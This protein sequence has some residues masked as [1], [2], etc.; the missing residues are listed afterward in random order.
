M[1]GG[2]DDGCSAFLFFCHAYILT[3]TCCIS[4]IFGQ[5]PAPLSPMF[6]SVKTHI[7]QYSTGDFSQVLHQYTQWLSYPLK[8]IQWKCSCCSFAVVFV[9][10]VMLFT[11][12]RCSGG[13]G[14]HSNCKPF[15]CIPNS[16]LSE[17]TCVVYAYR[18][19]Q[20]IYL[21]IWNYTF[22]TVAHDVC[23]YRCIHQNIQTI[24]K[25]NSYNSWYL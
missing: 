20:F 22:E 24:S 4:A 10:V 12:C 21:F 23:K 2:G 8:E 9:N 11:N 6:A 17:S 19:D 15:N 3:T 7:L 13:G 14:V 1:E 5:C 16:R 18:K 25:Y